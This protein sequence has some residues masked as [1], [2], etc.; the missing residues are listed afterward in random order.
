M[1]LLTAVAADEQFTVDERCGHTTSI[2]TLIQD[3]LQC[4]PSSPSGRINVEVN[5]RSTTGLT[6]T[7]GAGMKA[8]EVSSK[9]L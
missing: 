1:D 8:A 2:N 6:R 9:A 7:I 5:V 3:R 4:L